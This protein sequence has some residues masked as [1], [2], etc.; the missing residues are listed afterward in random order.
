[1]QKYKSNITTTSGAAVRGVPVL[2]IDEDGNNAALF[3]DR[4]GTVPAPNPL[5]TGPDGVFYFYAANGRYSIRTTVEGVTITDDDVVL[6]MDP[7]EITV[8]GP[9]AE[10]VAAAEAAA[11][12]AEYAVEDSEIPALV[13]SV[14]NAV[15]DVNTSAGI[16]TTKAGEAAA[17]AGAAQGSSD[18]ALGYKNEANASKIA[19][20]GSATA[21]ATSAANAG[22]S[23]T[24]AA[25][26]AASIA[27]GPVA[28]LVGLMGAITQEQ[29]NT[30]VA[31]GLPISTATQTA[32]SGKEPSIAAG[33]AS[34]YRRGDKTWQDFAGAVRSA[35]LTG[36]STATA[37][38]VAAADSVLA[39]IGKLQAQV[40]LRAPLDSPA[41]T[42][43]P[44][45]PTAA[46]GTNSTQIAT[47]AHVKAQFASGG[48][49]NGV[50]FTAP[51]FQMCRQVM[52]I[53]ANSGALWTFPLAFTTF[54]P[55][56]VATA[57]PSS[58]SP[59]LAIWTSGTATHGV[60]IANPNGVDLLINVL[61]VQ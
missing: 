44:L 52:T 15:A 41:L 57:A 3:L 39:A 43:V 59:T 50:Y 12:R 34:Q 61:A 9:I 37:T 42:G 38:A 4:A 22:N 28:S 23:A 26:S 18:S 7:E 10:A 47:T 40:S 35:V 46:A 17:S 45:A 32:L 16:A 53:P 51:N 31:P 48:N 6:M 60:F 13:E 55:Q 8:A 54:P 58:G 56:V 33:T 2:V 25:A 14:Q 49:G 27:G 21:A 20:A 19:A 36:L 11:T 5:T 24:A 30:T 1:M 29:L